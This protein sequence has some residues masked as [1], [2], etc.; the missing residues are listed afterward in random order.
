MVKV[1]NGNVTSH[2]RVSGYMTPAEKA[3]GF[4]FT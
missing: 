3:L 1:G 2:E 4:P